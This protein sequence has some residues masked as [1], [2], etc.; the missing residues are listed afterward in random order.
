MILDINL[1]TTIMDNFQGNS[2]FS[3]KG[4]KSQLFEGIFSNLQK[5]EDC[6]DINYDLVLNILN[7]IQI[8]NPQKEIVE[9]DINHDKLDIISEN[10][11]DLNMDY[12]MIQNESGYSN[13]IDDI[14]NIFMDNNIESNNLF[15]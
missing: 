10:T 4:I 14:L 6:E 13:N 1:S 7:N 15:D 3:T 2:S 9:I 11:I 12:K 8:L 5:E